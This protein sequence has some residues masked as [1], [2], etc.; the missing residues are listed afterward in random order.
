MKILNKIWKG[1]FYPLLIIGVL[2]AS[3]ALGLFLGGAVLAV[4]MAVWSAIKPLPAI[5]SDKLWLVYLITGA[6]AGLWSLVVILHGC[7]PDS[8]KKHNKQDNGNH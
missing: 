5:C 1:L 6:P 3:Y 4:V 8:L 2:L 7:F